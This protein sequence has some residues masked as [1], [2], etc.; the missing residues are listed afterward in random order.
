V[1]G[2][3]RDISVLGIG[4][5]SR[6]HF[7]PGTT[8]AIHV[9]AFGGRPLTY[10]SAMVKHCAALEDGKWLLGCSLQR[11]LEIDEILAIG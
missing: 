8:L 9:T 2:N 11:P 6:R 5:L 1:V 4:I 3:I 10:L 7:A